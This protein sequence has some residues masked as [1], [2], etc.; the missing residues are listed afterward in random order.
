MLKIQQI[1]NPQTLTEVLCK[2]LLTYY[3]AFELIDQIEICFSAIFFF[4]ELLRGFWDFQLYLFE[5]N[6][7]DKGAFVLFILS[8]R[9]RYRKL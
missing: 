5:I 2:W 4:F 1:F 3:W 9:Q 6:I 8:R 7:G